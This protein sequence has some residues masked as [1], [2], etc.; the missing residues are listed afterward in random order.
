MTSN[1]QSFERLNGTNYAQ[2]KLRMRMLLIKE[3]TWD[4]VTGR[5]VAPAAGATTS[6]ASATSEKAPEKAP[7][8]TSKDYDA[9]KKRDQDA[10]GTIFLAVNDSELLHLAEC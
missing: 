9:W 3:G 8:S 1:I 6:T 2:W 5:S 7:E 10:L 4:I